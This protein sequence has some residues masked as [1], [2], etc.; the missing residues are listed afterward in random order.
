M[1]VDP[2][3]CSLLVHCLPRLNGEPVQAL[4][5][6]LHKSGYTYAKRVDM[7]HLTWLMLGPGIIWAN[8]TLFV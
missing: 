2:K 3:V 7:N 1:T 8:G 6:I 5:H 4:Q